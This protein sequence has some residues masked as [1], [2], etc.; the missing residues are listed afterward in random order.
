MAVCYKLVIFEVTSDRR[1][2][3]ACKL[4]E[5]IFL[6]VFEVA[7]K[8]SAVDEEFFALA[9]FLIVEP[10]ALILSRFSWERY[11]RGCYIR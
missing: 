11:L 3:H 6:T 8:D 7:F 10:L 4:A 5:A 9:V 1:A 2:I